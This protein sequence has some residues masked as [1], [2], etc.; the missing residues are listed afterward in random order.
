MNSRFK[1]RVWYDPQCDG[2]EPCYFYDVQDVYDGSIERLGWISCFGDLLDT[3]EQYTVE[4][5]TGLKD[6]NGKLIYEGDVVVV[7]NQYPYFDYADDV[8]HKS[9]NDTF[10]V[11]EHDAVPNYVGIVEWAEE[12]AQFVIVL[13]CVNPSKSGISNGWCHSFDED[14]NLEIIGNIHEME[15]EQ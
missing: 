12:I 4:Q 7:P 13:Q 8:P 14:E 3:P 15:I 1:F 6:C 10:G 9:L 2:L 5:C 11:I